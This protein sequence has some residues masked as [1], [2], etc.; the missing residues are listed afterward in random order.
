MTPQKS[1]LERFHEYQR[2]APKFQRSLSAVTLAILL[3][4]EHSSEYS[5][6]MKCKYYGDHGVPLR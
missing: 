3:C 5:P 2:L 1:T 6:F 4:G